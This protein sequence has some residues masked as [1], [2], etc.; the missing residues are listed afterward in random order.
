MR[1]MNHTTFGIPFVHTIERHRIAC[2]QRRNSRG[3]IDIVRNEQGLT[4]VEPKNKAL[5][6]TTVLVVGQ[7]PVY[8]TGSGYL[9]PTPLIPERSRQN[10]IACA[11][12]NMSIPR[13]IELIPADVQRRDDQK[14]C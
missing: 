8:D 12:I 4:G 13:A 11:R 14:W 1:P 2:L 10:L 7:H 3:K 5:M 6:A 9:E